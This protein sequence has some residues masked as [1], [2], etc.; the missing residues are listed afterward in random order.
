MR[1]R[2]LYRF[3]F[4]KGVIKKEKSREKPIKGFKSQRIKK[5]L[6]RYAVQ[7][8]I[9][10][11]NNFT[12]FWFTY[13]A[14]KE[15]LHVDKILQTIEQ[16]ISLTFEELC[17]ELIVHKYGDK[18]TLSSGS[19]WDKDIEIDLLIETKDGTIFAGEAKWKNHK[20]CT[21]ILKSLQKKCRRAELR[22]TCFVLCSK[23]GFSKELQSLKN[24]EIMLF[25]LKDFKELY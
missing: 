5:S 9:H 2:S 16:Y 18:N 1:G 12:R 23:S 13:V 11:C 3:L 17:N 20:I 25:E 10:F 14:Q 22:A 6:R 24:S 15:Y 21:N 4:E 8:K 19:Y 7:D